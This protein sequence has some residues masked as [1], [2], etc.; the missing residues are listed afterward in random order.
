MS[1]PELTTN[2]EH[3][4]QEQERLNEEFWLE[5]DEE[6]DRIRYFGPWAFDPMPPGMRFLT[7]EIEVTEEMV[8]AWDAM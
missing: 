8:E 4:R 1:E 6:R 5:E 3:E 2:Y 7:Y